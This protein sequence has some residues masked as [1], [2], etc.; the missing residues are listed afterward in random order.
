MYYEIPNLNYSLDFT[1]ELRL[2]RSTVKVAL[3]TAKNDALIR[4]SA[5]RVAEACKRL[6][7]VPELVTECDLV[8]VAESHGIPEKEFRE[9]LAS[10]PMPDVDTIVQLMDSVTTGEMPTTDEARGAYI[11]VTQSTDEIEDERLDAVLKPTKGRY[12]ASSKLRELCA[13]GGNKSPVEELGL[14]RRHARELVILYDEALK[15]K[16]AEPITATI[17]ELQDALMD[18]IDV[19]TS[20]ARILGPVYD[21]TLRYRVVE[22][23]IRKGAPCMR[24][25]KG[26][27]DHRWGRAA[28]KFLKLFR[29]ENRP[30]GTDIVPSVEES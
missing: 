28:Q 12:L 9:A 7:D 14:L 6:R 27:F 23:A 1:E 4:H 18:V 10:Q 26:D 29:S 11:V 15:T 20:A 19:G 22:L 13:G 24:G 25:E 8:A 16:K 3:D 30:R 2:L 5:K 17:M 21:Q